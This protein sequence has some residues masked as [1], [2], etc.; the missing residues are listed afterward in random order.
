MIGNMQI[1]VKKLEN[2]VKS[3]QIIYLMMI[4]LMSISKNY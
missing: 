1:Q 2:I 4:C 3:G